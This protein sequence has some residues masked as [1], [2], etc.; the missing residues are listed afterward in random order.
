MAKLNIGVV[1]VTGFEQ[2]CAL[3]WNDETKVGAITDPGGDVPRILSAIEQTGINVETIFLTHGHLDHAGGAMELKEKLGVELVGPHIDDKPVCESV[4]EIAAKYGMSGDMKNAYPDRWL[5]EGESILIGGFDFDVLHCPGH[6]PGHVVFYSE[7][8]KFAHVGDVL[9]RG[10][11]GRTDLPGGNHAQLI[12]SIKDKL[13]PLGDDISFL[14]GHGPGSTFG[15]ER[16]TNPFLQ[17]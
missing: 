1:P 5:S 9:F 2:N 11:I 12:A 6:S 14:C 8:Q 15:L 16:R 10:S 3:I 7:T 4:E 17:E 13:L